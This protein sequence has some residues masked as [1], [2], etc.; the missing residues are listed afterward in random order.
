MNNILPD[1]ITSQSSESKKLYQGFAYAL[2]QVPVIFL[3]GPA[4][5]ILQGIY[6]KY[7]GLA[8]TTVAAVVL[9]ARLFDAITD[10]LIG[11]FSDRY[12]HP[13]LGRKLFIVT[14]GLFFIVS[15]YF[16]Y[17]PFGIGSLW[18]DTQ[19]IYSDVSAVY[20]L[21]WFLAF[22][23]SFTL[24]EIPHLT[25]ASE[26]AL[27]AQERNKL[28]SLR[29][30]AT[31]L[32]I[33]LFFSVPLLPFFDSSEFTPKVLVWSVLVATLLMLPLLF[34]SV[35]IVPSGSRE[36]LPQAQ[37]KSA[38]KG[39]L[40]TFIKAI[41]FNKPF[42]IFIGAF[43]FSGTALGMWYG[44]LFLFVDVYLG[45][46][47][48]LSFAFVVSSGVGIAMLK[49]WVYLANRIG[50]IVS[51]GLGNLLM[52]LGMLGTGFLSP[53]ES[54]WLPL[55]L[56][57]VFVTGGSA[58]NMAIAPSLLSDIIDYGRWKFSLDNAATFFSLY[59]LV[60][61]ANVAI[62]GALGLAIAGSYGFEVSNTVQTDGAIDALRFSIAW[63]PALIILGSFVCIALTP[64]NVRRHKIIRRRLDARDLRVSRETKESQSA[65]FSKY[66]DSDSLTQKA[67][68]KKILLNH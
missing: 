20:F 44:L 43:F 45:M 7:F 27:N 37:S 28:F 49:L 55:L 29:A 56:C 36:I 31:Y 35:K 4:A 62:G 33:L 39:K 68:F 41:Y 16:L 9:I 53:G 22:Y 2:P 61:K 26:I 64:I 52:L 30:L 67:H 3:A 15:S 1:D 8:L 13:L 46:G 34:I 24:F 21:C 11:Y 5:S 59:A 63:I 19:Y 42:L 38:I 57:M 65:S 50:K 40:S 32:G 18:T 60:A 10:P 51:W 66:A 58:T 17:A 12:Q 14:G 48:K 47:D 25:W 6:A 54:N 23:F